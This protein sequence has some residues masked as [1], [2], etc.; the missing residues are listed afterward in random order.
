MKIIHIE[1]F[2][3]SHSCETCGSDCACGYIEY[4]ER[5]TQVWSEAKNKGGQL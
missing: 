2:S 5:Q 4:S 1:A 3:D